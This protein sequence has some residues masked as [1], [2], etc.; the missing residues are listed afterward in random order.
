MSLLTRGNR[1]LGSD[2]W[3]FDLPAGPQSGGSCPGASTFCAAI[4]YARK[5]HYTFPSVQGKYAANLK[6]WQTAP[7]KLEHTLDRELASLP[8]ATVIRLHTSGDFLSA[9]YVDMWS[10]L[11]TM[12]PHL[13][14]YAYTR[15]WTVRAILPALQCLRTLPNFT[16]WASTDD[17]MPTPPADWPSTRIVATFADAPGIAHCPEQ[18]GKRASCQDCGLCWNPS[19]RPS[20]RLAFKLH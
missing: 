5:G 17:T 2:V 19:L 6:L 4:C 16:L 9:A 11:A 8:A 12:H 1:K 20:A 13:T 7:R 14:F 10:R 18:S 3:H 15:S